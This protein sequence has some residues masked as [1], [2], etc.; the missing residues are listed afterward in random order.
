[1]RINNSEGTYFYFSYEINDDSLKSGDTVL[2][3]L[4]SSGMNAEVDLITLMTSSGG[5]FTDLYKEIVVP[6]M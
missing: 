6:V 3:E 5:F 4:K 1:M 2:V